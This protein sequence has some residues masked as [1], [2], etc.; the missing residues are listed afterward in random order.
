MPPFVPCITIIIISPDRIS[1]VIGPE[2]QTRGATAPDGG[3]SL[4]GTR[5]D[6]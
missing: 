3:T 6:G 2:A 1:E 5:A 4:T